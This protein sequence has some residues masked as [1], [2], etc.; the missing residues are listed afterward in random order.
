MAGQ[1]KKRAKRKA[2]A[3]QVARVAGKRSVKRVGSDHDAPAR[4]GRGRARA[5][6]SAG[7][8]GSGEA[9]L[10]DAW[11]RAEALAG[12]PP[13]VGKLLRLA[14][15]SDVP[16]QR[17]ALANVRWERFAHEVL[18]A[19]S[20]QAAAVAAGFGVKGAR[21]AAWRMLR[22]VEVVGRMLYL[23]REAARKRVM[24]KRD[25]LAR[26]SEMGTA[27]YVDLLPLIGMKVSEAREWLADHPELAGSVAGLKVASS[28]LVAAV[29]VPK[30]ADPEAY[31]REITSPR[32]VDVDLHGLAPLK[33][34]ADLLGW[35]APKVS[36]VAVDTPAGNETLGTVLER[37]QAQ[38]S[39]ELPAGEM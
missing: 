4:S 2:A 9:G 29:T 28:E 25:A 14:E 39:D 31:A 10:V 1:P 3:K 16:L 15:V 33:M 21:T 5:G 27:R 18:K 35:S 36:A 6:A 19:S 11:G 37:I 30:G 20:Y 17:R 32:V 24:R 23:Q 22:N 8:G 38:R 26:L 7:S 12:H 34:L 13:R